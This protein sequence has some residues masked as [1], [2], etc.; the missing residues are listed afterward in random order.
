MKIAFLLGNCSGASVLTLP[1]NAKVAFG[2]FFLPALP[3][4]P[5]PS[6]AAWLELRGC[7]WAQGP[8][9]FIHLLMA[10]SSVSNQG[11]FREQFKAAFSSCLPGL[12]PCDSPKAP[13]PR[14]SASHKSL[15]LH[16]RYSVSKVPEHVVLT[17]VTTVLP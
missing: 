13:S 9:C 16:S 14:S 12:G 2:A 4:P 10:M 3:C 17:S 1:G 6:Q 5:A 11:K 7:S 15:S 8:S